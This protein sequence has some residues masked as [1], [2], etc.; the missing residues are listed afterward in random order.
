MFGCTYL[1][2]LY[3]LYNVRSFS[4]KRELRSSF[5]EEVV[6]VF[7]ITWEQTLISWIMSFVLLRLGFFDLIYNELVN[8]FDN[9]LLS[10]EL[11]VLKGLTRVCLISL[12]LNLVY[13]IELSLSTISLTSIDLSTLEEFNEI[14]YP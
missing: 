7:F 10:G 5:I 2:L 14:N 6:E 1:Y 4:F 12:I 11:L 13:L 9:N 3:L 8:L